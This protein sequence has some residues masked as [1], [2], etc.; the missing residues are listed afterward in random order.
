[1]KVM[2]ALDYDA[3]VCRNGAALLARQLAADGAARAAALAADAPHALLEVL[4]THA[5]APRTVMSLMNAYV[6]STL[7]VDTTVNVPGSTFW[8]IRYK[9]PAWKYTGRTSLVH[10]LMGGE[11]IRRG[12][13]CVWA[14][15]ALAVFQGA[16]PKF[17]AFCDRLP[18]PP[19]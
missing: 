6:P 7:S 19:A 16:P 1:V 12:W 5:G 11:D 13:C 18:A 2:R 3:D 4:D 8:S 15:K 14:T 17:G 10:S 9:R